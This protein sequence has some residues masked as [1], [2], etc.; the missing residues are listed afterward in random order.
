VLLNLNPFWRNVLTVMAGTIL[1]QGIPM[2]VLLVL[3][4]IVPAADIGDFSLLLSA[5]SMCSIVAAASLD[6]AIFSAR[7]EEEI[8]E[9]LRLTIVTGCVVGIMITVAILVLQMLGLSIVNQTIAKYSVCLVGYSLL[10]AFNRNL[11]AVITYRSQFWLLN[12]AKLLFTTPAALAQLIAGLL[13]FGVSGL[14]YATTLLSVISTFVSMNWLSISWGKLWNGISIVSVRKTFISNRRFVLFSLPADLIN[15]A[16]GQLPIFIIAAR[17]GSV[18][19][20]MYSLML[21]LLSI[22]VGLLG[23]SVLTVFKDKAGQDYRENGNCIDIYLKTLKILA[24][25]SF[26]PFLC[27]HLFGS[28]IVQFLLGEQWVAAGQ[29]T[30]ILSPMLFISF[31]SSPLSYVLYFSKRG[32]AIDL[33]C[34]II[35]TFIMWVAF[36]QSSNVNDAILYYSILGSIYYVFY[37]LVSYRAASGIY[38]KQIL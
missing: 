11:Q 33:F 5:S 7:T 19:V 20:A 8:T 22:P 6:K 25:L 4:R 10:L 37:L 15:S 24:L 12:K 35:L 31:I 16:S 38:S 21:R 26:F 3:T 1:S 34:Q 13:G 36:S 9:L 23:S 29:Y 18:S 30:E 27:L 17:F 2:A 32:Q 14:I 28:H